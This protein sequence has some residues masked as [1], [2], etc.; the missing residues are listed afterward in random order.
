MRYFA[1]QG[2]YFSPPQRRK[3]VSVDGRGD[4]LTFYCFHKEEIKPSLPTTCRKQQTPQLWIEGRGRGVGCF[5]VS[6]IFCRRLQ[7]VASTISFNKVEVGK[8]LR[9]AGQSNVFNKHP[10][11][12]V[13]LSFPHIF[14]IRWYRKKWCF[15]G[16]TFMK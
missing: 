7:Q 5:Y 12:S 13:V 6:T 14:V 16:V 2:L 8:T 1:L 9:W 10:L 3:E 15:L 11:Y 4:F